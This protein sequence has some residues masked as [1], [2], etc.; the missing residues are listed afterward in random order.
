MRVSFEH[1]FEEIISLENL[2]A[3][4][5][6]FL[7]G[8][9]SRLDVQIFA[10]NL[11][12]N[13]FVL[14]EDLLQ[15]SYRHGSYQEF[16]ISDPKPRL[17]HKA[18]VRDRVIH[19]LLYKTLCQYFDKQFVFD[20]YSCREGKGAHK[21]LDRFKYFAAKMSRNHTET[22]YVLKCDIRKFFASI[23][24]VILM[25]ILKAQIVDQDLLWLIGQVLTS[26][27][28]GLDRIGLPLGNLTSQLFSN[29]YLNELDQFVKKDL[30]IKYYIRYAD[31]FVILSRDKKE[32]ECI[33]PLLNDFLN[34]KLRLNLHP[35]KLFIK[36][37]ASGVDFL[38]WV[39]FPYHRV[40]RTATK[41]R[42]LSNL[43]RVGDNI[44]VLNSYKGLLSH[45]NSY[46]LLDQIKVLA[47]G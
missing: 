9:T 40:L 25:A 8:K 37:W 6:G 2:L 41:R 7:L 46:K 32:L 10:A 16:R 17:I 12:N 5:Q 28:S 1:N 27:N 38:G 21:A 45:G 13:L 19:H 30:Q 44:A 26:F 43:G 3:A 42:M 11:M 39:H 47:D 23:D 14:Q 18:T 20:S 22:C 24:Q 15:R 34:S 4:W 35:D 31:D 33:V 36:T 29:I